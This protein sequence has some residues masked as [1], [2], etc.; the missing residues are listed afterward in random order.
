MA[1]SFDK[2]EILD[3][4][5]RLNAEL[6]HV[7]SKNEFRKKSGISEWWVLKYFSGWRETVQESGL[8]PDTSSL[9]IDDTAL[10]EDWGFFVR[11]NRK[12]PTLKQYEHEGKYNAWTLSKRFGSW[13]AIPTSFMEFAKD[14]PKWKDVLALLPAEKLQASKKIKDAPRKSIHQPGLGVYV[15]PSRLNELNAIKNEKK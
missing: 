8:E 6:G 7:P 1:K 3:A 10:L 4:I 15:D 9:K 2:I 12:I 5:R 11:Q 14:K 13:S